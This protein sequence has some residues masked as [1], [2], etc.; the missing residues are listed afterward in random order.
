MPARQFDCWVLGNRE[1]CECEDS[2]AQGMLFDLHNL[3][4]SI[5]QV[6]VLRSNERYMEIPGGPNGFGACPIQ[7]Q[8]GAFEPPDCLKGD[9]ARGWLYMSLRHGVTITPDERDMFERWSTD[10]PVSPWESQR[11]KR[12]FDYTS[13]KT[14]S[15]IV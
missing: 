7:D 9:L 11:E 13:S 12:V 1:A 15:F 6:N 5:G 10:D 4:P 8:Q 2:R 3:A 14:L